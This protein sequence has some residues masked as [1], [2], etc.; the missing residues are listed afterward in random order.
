MK[1]IK[2]VHYLFNLLLLDEPLRNWW[3]PSK[4]EEP[5]LDGFG[6]PSRLVLD[7]CSDLTISFAS[8]L[9]CLDL[10]DPPENE[11]AEFKKFRLG[12]D[13]VKS[14][15]SVGVEIGVWAREASL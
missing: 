11:P 13:L 1:S 10:V 9:N 4:P 12:W 3:N 15:D 7:A 14:P 6:L 8:Y 2:V 5:L